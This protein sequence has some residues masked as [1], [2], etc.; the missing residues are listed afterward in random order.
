MEIV[1]NYLNRLSDLLVSIVRYSPD[2]ELIY[3]QSINKEQD[4][5]L[6]LPN[7]VWFS[8]TQESSFEPE[9][10]IDRSTFHI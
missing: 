2:D 9:S 6:K 5:I 3:Q 1:I 4:Q 8:P 7:R 10:C